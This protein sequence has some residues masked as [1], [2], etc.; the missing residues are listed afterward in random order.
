[1]QTEQTERGGQLQAGQ[2]WKIEHGY[3]FIVEVGK[4]LVHYKTLRQPDQ[5]AA[6][7]RMIGLE[8]LLRYLTQCEGQLAT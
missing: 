7:T 5:R 4:R 3:V 8:A 1:M 6:V 2:L